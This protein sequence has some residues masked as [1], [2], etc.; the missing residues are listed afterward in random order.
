MN[1]RCNEAFQS[2]ID[3]EKRADLDAVAIHHPTFYHILR[4]ACHIPSA[5]QDLRSQSRVT[6][7]FRPTTYHSI[8]LDLQA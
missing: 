3:I 7:Y 8:L 4:N 5:I 6:R 2:F 1:Q